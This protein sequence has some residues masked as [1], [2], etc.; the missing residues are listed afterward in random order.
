MP[1]V[2]RADR[3]GGEKLCMIFPIAALHQ[4]GFG[5]KQKGVLIVHEV[6]YSRVEYTREMQ[7]IC[8]QIGSISTQISN[9]SLHLKQMF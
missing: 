7:I 6:Q 4:A 8:M 5:F 2:M 9:T 1:P 3:Y